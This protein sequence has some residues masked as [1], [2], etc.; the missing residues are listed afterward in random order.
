MFKA[1]FAEFMYWCD[2][3]TRILH[4]DMKSDVFTVIPCSEI[5]SDNQQRRHAINVTRFGYYLLPHLSL[6]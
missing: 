4:I 1:T 2:I 5:F 6:M 3:T